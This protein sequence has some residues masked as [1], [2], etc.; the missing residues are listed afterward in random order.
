MS[1]TFKS[2]N[3]IIILILIGALLYT[4]PN[5]LTNNTAI[6]NWEKIGETDVADFPAYRPIFFF[7]KKNGV[8]L[9]G[10]AINA[11]E[12]GGRT[13]RSSFYFK[14]KWL[15]ALVFTSPETGWAVGQ[16]WTNEKRTR[17]VV[18]RTNDQ[19]IHWEEIS[20]EAK[21]LKRVNENF[22]SFDDICFEKNG[23]AWLVGEGKI[24]E[25][26]FHEKN[27]TVLNLF[28]TNEK[29]YHIFC[30]DSGRIWA[31]G[32]NGAVA[33]YDQNQWHY[34]KLGD[35]KLF[36]KII[37]NGDYLWLM[38]GF[39]PKRGESFG[40]AILLRSKDRGLTWEDKTP[41]SSGGLT[42]LHFE[43]NKGWIVG[44]Q[45]VIYST[46]NSGETWTKEQSPTQNRLFNIFFLD[47]KNGWISGDKGTILKYEN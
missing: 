36:S 28:E 29:L 19:A 12:D 20:F 3:L 17:P 14:N 25:A 45:G 10:T 6:L 5:L 39:L 7:D 27:L 16:E 24:I 22:S 30:G 26:E 15:S 42:D 18:L 43:D 8:G 2:I 44:V 31:V 4:A 34:Q 38:G 23:K 1:F 40:K 37:A 11:T 41:P 13:W 47:S 35:E 21:S 32:M 9:I 46:I 33:Y